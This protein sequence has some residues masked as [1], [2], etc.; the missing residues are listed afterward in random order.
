MLWI[1]LIAMVSLPII[2]LVEVKGAR[3]IKK[4]QVELRSIFHEMNFCELKDDLPNHTKRVLL[5]NDIERLKL[6][7]LCRLC[8]ER[9]LQDKRQTTQR[10]QKED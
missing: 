2:L 7:S 5:K 8:R 4:L 9:E 10:E 6:C 3:E 1:L